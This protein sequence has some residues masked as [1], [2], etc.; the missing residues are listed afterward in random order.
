MKIITLIENMVNSG[1]L[2]GE[3]GLSLYIETSDQKILFDTGQSGMFLQNAKT[4]GI[5]IEEIDSLVLSHGH[6]D[7]T[8]GLYPFLEKNSKAK[9]YAKRNIFIPKYKNKK[10]FIGTVNKEELLKNRLVYIDSITEIAN[11]LFLMPEINIYNSV[12][13]NFESFTRKVGNKHATDYFDDELFMVIKQPK[14]INIITACS[15]RGISNICTTATD[16]FKLPVDLI[17]GGFHMKECK[18]EQ[19]VD[20]THYFRLLQPKS[21]GVC[22]C[23]GIEKFADL[24]RECQAHLFYNF[25]GN[26]IALK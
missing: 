8:G 13:T 22:H 7:H 24:Y 26:E 23:T 19:Y 20:I 18:V 21:I 25:T 4:L 9:V 10:Q 11:N 16:H 6:Y 5:L 2:H 17:L 12:D 3:H 15:H 1:D 14:H